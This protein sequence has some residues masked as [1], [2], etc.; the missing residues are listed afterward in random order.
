MN[1]VRQKEKCSL[2]Y[3]LFVAAMILLSLAAATPALAQQCTEAGQEE[4]EMTVERQGELVDR[5][6]TGQH[7]RPAFILRGRR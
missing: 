2:G 6:R 1:C 5:Q 4:A 7:G 3:V